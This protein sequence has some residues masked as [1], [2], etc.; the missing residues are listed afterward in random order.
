[1]ALRPRHLVAAGMMVG[2][3]VLGGAT[4]ASAQDSPSTT[5]GGSTTTTED[6]NRSDAGRRSEGR[7]PEE[8]PRSREDCPHG[9]G[10]SGRD[11]SDGRDAE[12]SVFWS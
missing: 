3:V 11:S 10:E 8:T 12:A 9:D 7:A 1:M 5:D 2:A 4:W 6:D